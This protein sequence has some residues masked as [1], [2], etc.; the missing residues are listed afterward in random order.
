M[1]SDGTAVEGSVSVPTARFAGLY[2]Q[3]DPDTPADITIRNLGR[4]VF[5]K[6]NARNSDGLQ[7]FLEPD[8][9][10]VTDAVVVLLGAVVANDTA[11]VTLYL[12][13]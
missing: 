1:S 11:K 7:E 4:N 12:D 9:H 13:Y 2:Y 3:F 8:M 5:Q 10:L 6:T